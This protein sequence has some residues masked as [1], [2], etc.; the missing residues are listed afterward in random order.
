MH[1][2]ARTRSSAVAGRPCD[3]KACQGLLKWT[4]KWQPRLKWLSNVMGY[5]AQYNKRGLRREGSE[6]ITSE[7]SEN[8][9][10]PTLIWRPLQRTPAHIRIKLTVLENRIPGLYTF[11]PLTVWYGSIF[12]QILVVG[13]ETHVCNATAHN[14]RPRS[15][16]GQP[17]SLI[18]L[19]IESAYMISY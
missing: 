7:R 4:W 5:I 9:H 8:R 10:K 2:A 15:F 3:A 1:L 11:L 14:C 18:L 19:P 16:Q 17:R 12:M 6:D 13:S